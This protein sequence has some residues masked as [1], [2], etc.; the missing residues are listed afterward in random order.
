MEK[1]RQVGR[2]LGFP[3]ANIR[4]PSEKFSIKNGVYAG[5]AE[6]DGKVYKGI[7]NYGSRPTF[8]NGEVWTETYFDGFDG[9]LYGKTLK[10]RFTKFLRGIQ[11]SR[12]FAF[13]TAL[14]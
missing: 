14:V 7:I 10:I 2:T 6:I 13:P 4:Y 3:T 1:D 5:E 12:A 8:Q 9:D 11:K